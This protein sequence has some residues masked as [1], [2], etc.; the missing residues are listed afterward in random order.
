MLDL[1]AVDLDTIG[2]ALAQQADYEHWWLIDNRTGEVAFWTSDTGI[3]G[4]NPVDLDDLDEHLV[5]IDP[6]PSHVWFQDMADFANGIT[7]DRAGQRLAR[8]LEGRG[9]FRR[10]K[11]ELYRHHPDLIPDWHAFRDVR[12]Q[13]RAVEWLLDRGLI[14]EAA[15][16]R[17]AADHPDPALH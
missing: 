16:R 5:A 14:D 11:D 9:P 15:G 3:D 12:E 10:F 17:F 1:G 13:R 6:L 2:T 8:A 7:D 4:E